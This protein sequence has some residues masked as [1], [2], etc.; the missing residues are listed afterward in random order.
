MILNSFKARQR[1][2]CRYSDYMAAILHFLF[3][4]YLNLVKI[5]H[6][7]RKLVLSEKIE[8]TYYFSAI[9]NGG[10]YVQVSNEVASESQ[11]T[12]VVITVRPF[13]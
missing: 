9:F 7:R 3:Y 5:G 4:S 2:L 11:L 6:T 12:F 10:T 8:G 13:V 1:G